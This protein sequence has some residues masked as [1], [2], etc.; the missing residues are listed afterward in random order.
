V[1]VLPILEAVVQSDKPLLI[2]PITYPD[3]FAG[4]G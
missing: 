1:D 4:L 2:K 3:V